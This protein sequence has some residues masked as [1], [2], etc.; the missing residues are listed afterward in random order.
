[1][2]SF[3]QEFIRPLNQEIE[4]KVKGPTV[5]AVKTT[6]SAVFNAVFLEWPADTYW[7]M[8]N[9][10]IN[11]G[12]PPSNDFAVQPAERPPQRGALVGEQDVNRIVQIGKL[13]GLKYGDEVKIGNAVPYAKDVAFV[14]GLG[15]RLYDSA[16]FQGATQATAK[17]RR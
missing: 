12:Q 2:P 8:A 4:T 5:E 11:I 15:E 13:E 9:H 3:E 1:M 14:D 6:A 16:A 10:R 17:L 7:S